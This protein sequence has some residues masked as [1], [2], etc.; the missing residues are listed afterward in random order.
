MPRMFLI[1]LGI[2]FLVSNTLNILRSYLRQSFRL[3]GW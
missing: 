1:P 3:S 2:M